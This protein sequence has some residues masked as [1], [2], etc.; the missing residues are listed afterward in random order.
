MENGKSY[1]IDSME[2]K[3]EE[4]EKK[5]KQFTKCLLKVLFPLLSFWG[6]K[7]M[8]AITVFV[9]EITV[10]ACLWLIAKSRSRMSSTHTY[11]HFHRWKRVFS[12]CAVL[13]AKRIELPLEWSVTALCAW[14]VFVWICGVCVSVR[15]QEGWTSGEGARGRG[16]GV[17][18][19]CIQ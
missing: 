8:N 1:V 18:S 2:L 6:P 16:H 7:I 3:K 11:S 10:D 5:S 9:L 12:V 15:E 19:N 17:S 14:F 13:F 4:K